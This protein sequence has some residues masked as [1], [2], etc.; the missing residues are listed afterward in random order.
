MFKIIKE[1][2]RPGVESIIMFTFRSKQKTLD[3]MRELNPEPTENIAAYFYNPFT[4][5]IVDFVGVAGKEFLAYCESLSYEW[6]VVG[7][8]LDI[9]PADIPF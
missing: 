5:E 4:G 9:D 7:K 6:P 8:A 3:K 1:D 2:C